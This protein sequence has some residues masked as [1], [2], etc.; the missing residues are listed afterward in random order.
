MTG[1]GHQQ[2]GFEIVSRRIV[3]NFHSYISSYAKQH[4]KNQLNVSSQ[5]STNTIDLDT[6]LVSPRFLLCF[7]C[8]YFLE[9]W[10]EVPENS[11]NEESVDFKAKLL[12]LPFSLSSSQVGHWS[13]GR[14]VFSIEQCKARWIRKAR[15]SRRSCK[16]L[17]HHNL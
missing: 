7:L 16:V 14:T 9:V 6:F 10:L 3:N 15:P 5:N 17:V 8:L 1:L 13:L 2:G 11:I 12:Y 4:L